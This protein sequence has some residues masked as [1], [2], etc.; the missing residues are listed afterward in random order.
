MLELF[1]N[2]SESTMDAYQQTFPLEKRWKDRR[3]IHQLYPLLVHLLLFGKS[4]LQAIQYTLKKY[5]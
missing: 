4:Y 2:I 5:A 1:G 3:D